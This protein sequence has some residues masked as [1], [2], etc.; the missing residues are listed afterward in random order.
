MNAT[1]NEKN[2]TNGLIQNMKSSGKSYV[3][4]MTK[5]TFDLDSVT[6]NQENG[7]TIAYISDCEE[8]CDIYYTEPGADP[9]PNKKLW[10][11]K[12]VYDT[13]TCKWLVDS[14]IALDTF[15]P[16]NKREY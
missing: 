4:Y 3:G 10:K 7:M 9:L 6:V 1:D 5:T 12:M 14:H 11:Y 8:F 15:N 13:N 16:V 2:R